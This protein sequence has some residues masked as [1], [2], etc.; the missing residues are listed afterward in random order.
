MAHNPCC[1]PCPTIGFDEAA[2]PG[3]VGC[4]AGMAPIINLKTNVARLGE[5]R[6]VFGGNDNSC[7]S[8][9]R[10]SSGDWPAVKTYIEQGGR[11]WIN[12]EYGSPCGLC[13]ADSNKLASFLTALGSSM[14][15]LNSC[16]NP[17]AGAC[18]DC[19]AGDANIASGA[20]LKK[21]T[22]ANISGGTPVWKSASENTVV[23]VEQLGDGFLFLSGDSNLQ[24]V[25]TGFC[26][27]FTRVWEYEG[28]DII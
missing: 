8:A 5:C 27:F 2:W 7:S 26:D 10:F 4:C 9:V 3:L 6:V 24:N 12:A 22:S 11:L 21:A 20:T 16:D 25:C 17:E 18:V 19:V 13:L 1:C 23:A 15:W 28:A 14:S